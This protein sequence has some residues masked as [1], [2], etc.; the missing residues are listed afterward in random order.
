MSQIVKK[1]KIVL[2]IVIALFCSVIIELFGFNYKYWI[3]SKCE[4]EKVLYYDD[5]IALHDISRE[6]EVYKITGESPYFTISAKGYSS[7]VGVEIEENVKDYKIDVQYI[8]NGDIKSSKEHSISNIYKDISML[9]IKNNIENIRFVPVILEQDSNEFSFRSLSIQN[10][11]IINYYRISALFCSILL[12]I[13]LLLY[14]E[15]LYNKLHIIFLLIVILLGINIALINPVYYSYDEREHFVRAYQT[16]YF[17]FEFFENQEIPWVNNSDEFLQRADYTRLSYQNI[18]EKNNYMKKYNSTDYENSYFYDSTAATYPFIPYI[19]GAIGIF[20][21]RLLGFSFAWTFFFG[22]ITSLLGYGVICAWCL[23]NIKIG[24]KTLFMVASLPALFFVATSYSADTYTLAF[25]FMA[26]TCWSNMLLENNNIKMTYILGF[27]LAISMVIMCKITYAPLCLLFFAIPQNKFKS[28][29][30]AVRN[31]LIVVAW[32]G[33][34]TILTLLYSTSK[35]INQWNI[36]GVD[37]GGQVKFILMH[38]IQYITIIW[39]DL[40]SN[41]IKYLSGSISSLAYNVPLKPIWMILILIAVCIVALIEK[42]QNASLMGKKERGIISISLICSWGLVATA[43]YITFTPVGSE[44]IQGIQ[45]RY[46]GPLLF[47]LFLLLK[48]AHIETTF[49]EKKFNYLLIIFTII[50]ILLVL[51]SVLYHCCG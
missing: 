41:F 13:F 3:S 5:K 21:G 35:D 42:E 11:L 19:P 29:F 14:R 9:E 44:T 17:D 39:N 22:R 16:S 47:P 20:I 24:K 28:K 26:I 12:I 49:N 25:V 37:V 36:P 31:K 6:G 46:M 32:S 51:W 7:Y 2:L 50:P 15:R 23:K 45:G 8:E 18:A 10:N 43:L 27:V 4:P 48:N 30:Y 40:S 1:G 34:M 33:L 38:P